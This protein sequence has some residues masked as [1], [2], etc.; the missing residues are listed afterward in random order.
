M[1][2]HTY[3]ILPNCPSYIYIYILIAVTVSDVMQSDDAHSS[4]I[5][6]YTKV[7][8]YL[9]G[10]SWHKSYKYPV[11]V[12]SLSAQQCDTI[13]TCITEGCTCLLRW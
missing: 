10:Q 13:F 1:H 5:A 4:I 8:T 9:E 3:A 11:H 7:S 6:Y 12:Y 2:V